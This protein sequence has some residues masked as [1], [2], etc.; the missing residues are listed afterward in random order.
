ME[1]YM[2]NHGR[3]I[4]VSKI[5]MTQFPFHLI[6]LIFLICLFL[7]IANRTNRIQAHCLSLTIDLSTSM[8][9]PCF[10]KTGRCVIIRLWC[11]IGLTAYNFSIRVGLLLE[12]N[13]RN[14]CL[15]VLRTRLLSLFRFKR[16]IIKKLLFC[17]W[18]GGVVGM[19]VAGIGW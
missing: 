19:V 8:S 12:K 5:E 4:V 7:Y 15:S 3:K 9:H 1:N 16:T 6:C 17:L 10:E 18:Q 2:F 14:A 11:L 13:I